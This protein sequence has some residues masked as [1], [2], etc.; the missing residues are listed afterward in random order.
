LLPAVP[1]ARSIALLRRLPRDVTDNELPVINQGST[2]PGR[3][4][5]VPQYEIGDHQVFLGL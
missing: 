4:H 1:H 3:L 5:L 2:L